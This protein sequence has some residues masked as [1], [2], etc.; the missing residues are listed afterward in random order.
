MKNLSEKIKQKAMELGFSAAGVTSP[1]ELHEGAKDL[2]EFLAKNYHG[3]MDWMAATEKERTS[4]AVFFPDVKSI[5]VVAHNY[6]RND[7]EMMAPEGSGTISLYAQGRDYHRVVRKK[8][9]KLLNWLAEQTPDARG[10]IFVDSFPIMEKPLAQRAGIGWIAKNTTL[11][12]KGKGSYFFLGGILLNIDLPPDQPSTGD[13]CGKC[14]RC[15]QACPTGALVQPFRIDASRCISY[16]TIEHKGEIDP[17]FHRKMGN[18]IFGCD[19]CQTVCPWNRQFSSETEETDFRSRFRDSDLL[20][21]FL[22]GIKRDEFEKMFEGTPVRRAGYENF[23][24]NVEI[25]RSNM[26]PNRKNSQRS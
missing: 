6:Y 18:Y 4:P 2:G 14:T 11:I 22:A 20:L 1:G 10:R 19:I 24:R 25:A 23:M 12:I 5:L 17:L 21:S 26:S 9:K 13:F 7:E 8:L 16:L 3:T 15:Q